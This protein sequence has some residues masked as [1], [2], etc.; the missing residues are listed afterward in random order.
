MSGGKLAGAF[1][2]PEILRLAVDAPARENHQSIIDGLGR[3]PRK[4]GFGAGAAARRQQSYA[5]GAGRRPRRGL[6]QHG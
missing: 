2:K 6:G 1:D 4:A 5:Q 3:R